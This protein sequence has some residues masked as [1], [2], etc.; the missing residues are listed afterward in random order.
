MLRMKDEKLVSLT[1]VGKTHPRI[2]QWKAGSFD[3]DLSRS[4][5]VM[6]ILNVTPDSFSDGGIYLR[7]EDAIES[8]IRMAHAGAGIIDIGGE[9]TRPGAAAVSLKEELLRV[10]PV[11]QEVRAACRGVAVSVDTSK[12]D[13]A[14]ACIREGADIVN[15]V[16]GLCGDPRMAEVVAACDAGLVIMHMQGDPRN[17]QKAPV[18]GDVVE[19]VGDY[20]SRQLAFA[21]AAG[22]A[23]DRVVVDPG[24]GFGKSL[25]HNLALLRAIPQL[26]DH[27]GRP[28]LIGVSRKSMFAA[29]LGA[30]A[31]E[32]RLWPTV[33][34]TCLARE[35][36]ARIHRVHDI[37]ENVQALKMT[38]AILSGG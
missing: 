35:L 14:R 23:R 32:E 6:G 11:V 19:E 8:A 9:S 21:E 25:D 3:F 30:K 38:E 16:T 34:T 26:L 1:M 37:A 13:V 10:V 27:I 20:L 7:V 17:M 2:H 22:V 36:G 15:D 28:V 29:L 33:A 18:Y 31:V 5:V 4:G 24:I 12:S